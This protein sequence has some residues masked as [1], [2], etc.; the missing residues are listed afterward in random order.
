MSDFLAEV[1]DSQRAVLERDVTV[2]GK[3]GK[4]H[5]R[6]I[7]AGE[8]QRLLKGSKM[9]KQGGT[10][11]FEV[12]LALNEEQKHLLILFSVCK[13]DG[14]PYFA[15]LDAVRKADSALVTALYKVAS[16]L[17]DEGEEEEA[18]KA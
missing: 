14:K 8:R 4:V 13:S 1:L 6:R 18:K 7:T 16:D 11:S 12:D 10:T 17:E 2:G 5:F 15:D 3:T 9:T